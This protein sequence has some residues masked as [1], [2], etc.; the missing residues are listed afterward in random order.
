VTGGAGYIGSHTL[1][2]LFN[3]KR[4]VLVVDNFCRSSRNSLKRVEQLVGERVKLIEG[5]IRDKGFLHSVFENYKINSVIHFA[6]LKAVGEST[7]KP[8]KYYENNFIGTLNLCEVMETFNVKKLVF[9]SSATVYGDPKAVPINESSPTGNTTNPYGTSKY[10]VECLLKDLCSSD[11]SWSTIALR[12]FNPAGAHSSGLIGE[13]PN[14]VPNNLIPYVSQVAVGKLQQLN[15]YG[16]DYPTPDGTGIRDYI[17]VVDL[18]KGHLS[19]L[20]MLESDVPIGFDAVNLGTG[21]GCSVLE[22]IEA[23]EKAS[24]KEVPYNIVER[25]PGDIA[26]CYADPSYAYKRLKW[27]ARLGVNDMMRDVWN[28]QSKNPNGY[29]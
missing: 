7:L 4:Q 3:A 17:H 26:I 28:W 24:K 21:R 10:M 8:V 29:S 9:S 11:P 18:A 5:D 14:G 2:E 6:G 27:K 1:V 15:V 19:A 16:G 22:V 12:Y 20:E 25:R 23:F 13:D